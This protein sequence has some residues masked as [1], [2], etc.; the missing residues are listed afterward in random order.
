MGTAAAVSLP[1]DLVSWVEEVG[2]GA[3]V[4]ADR[5]PG[6]ARKEAWFVDLRRD[7]GTVN[8]CFLRYDRSDPAR[9]KDPWT[10]HREATVYL[11]LQGTDVPV[12]R[13]LG[14]H[15]VHQAMLSERVEGE[16]WFSRI[17]RRRRSRRRRHSDF[18]TKLAALHALDAI[19]DGSSGLSGGDDREG[20][21]AG[22]ARRVGS[23][24][25]P[26]GVACPIRR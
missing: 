23:G 2:G 4:E 21:G 8:Q 22:G 16:T 24:S 15:P 10:L 14:V 11:A 18:M 20:R 13:V 9:T 6:G 17:A 3:L 26:T 12:P 5:K 1:D 7:D 19:V 25:W